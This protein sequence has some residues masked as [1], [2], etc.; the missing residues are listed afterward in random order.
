MVGCKL[1]KSQQGR[2]AAKNRQ[3]RT[4]ARMNRSCATCSDVRVLAG[5]H[6]EDQTW[7]W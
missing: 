7:S 4:E 6:L 2:A 5:P 3:G 1:S